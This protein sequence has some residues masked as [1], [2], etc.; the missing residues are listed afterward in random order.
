MPD[1]Q[2]ILI[3]E[4]DDFN[5]KLLRELCEHTGYQVF[6]ARSGDEAITKAT[7]EPFDLVLLDLLLS[8]KDGFDV[9]LELRS[10]RATA[11]LPI[12]IVTALDDLES[13]ALGIELGADDY[14][15]KPFRMY[16]LQ[17][18]MRMAMDIRKYQR[19]LQ[20]AEDKLR[21]LGQLDTP[22]R[23][24]G[25]RQLRHTLNQEFKRAQRYEHPLC[26][27][28][29]SLDD[30]DKLHEEGTRVA[31][32]AISATIS[33]LKKNLRTV[34]RIFRVHDNAF[35][36]LMPETQPAGARAA[37]ERVRS[38]LTIPLR[39]DRG[40][41]YIT[42]ALATY[43][44]PLIRTG[45]DILRMVYKLHKEASAQSQEGLAEQE[46]VLAETKR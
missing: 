40:P 20:E 42:Q 26:C 31:A 6:E 38:E 34:D 39:P 22:G 21:K 1:S 23:I 19:Q 27:V 24:G 15:T 8:G 11:D 12:I 5:M 30:Y 13:K 36:I 35:I 9:C 10:R 45:E 37:V 43:P 4:D 46:D 17:Q 7:S 32:G 16:E 2:R 18:R 44:H 29:F 14:I 25:Y 33:I 28:L 3:V 41:I